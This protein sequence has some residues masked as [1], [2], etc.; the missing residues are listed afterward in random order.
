M[1]VRWQSDATEAAIVEA[2]QRHGL[3]RLELNSPASWSY[4][5][6]AWSAR[7]LDALVRDPLAADT[8]GIDRSNFAL[9]VPAPQGYFTSE[10]DADEMLKR[11]SERM[12]RS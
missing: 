12:C 5:L 11:V 2:E 1:N 4:E 10:H 3:A 8:H 7:D 6:T 9:Q